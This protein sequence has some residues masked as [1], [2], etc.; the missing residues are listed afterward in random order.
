MENDIISF[1]KKDPERYYKQAIKGFYI[2]IITY[3]ILL[4]TVLENISI[5]SGVLLTFIIIN[6]LLFIKSYLIK[7]KECK[8]NNLY[9]NS[10]RRLIRE[11]KIRSKNYCECCGNRYMVFHL[12]SGTIG[13]KLNFLVYNIKDPFDKNL[14]MSRQK[15]TYNIEDY[16]LVCVRCRNLLWNKYKN[17]K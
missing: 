3:T 11:I 12:K 10:Y 16:L 9:E 6:I 15:D 5:I 17:Q 2:L 14:H 7:V 8:N 13:K 1:S 4:I